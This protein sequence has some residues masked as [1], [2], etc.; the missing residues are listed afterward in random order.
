MQT[1]LMGILFERGFEVVAALCV[2]LASL[3]YIHMLQLESYQGKMY[4][5]WLFKRFWAEMLQFLLV[6]LIALLLRASYVFFVNT[7]ELIASICYIGADVV[8]VGMLL[9]MF[10]TARRG[11]PKKPLVF[12]GRIMR[13]C[14]T[15]CVL[16]FLFTAHFFVAVRYT[17]TLTWAQYLLPNVIRYLPGSIV[18]LFVMIAY[19]MIYP[20]EAAVKRWYFN[21]AKKK[22]ASRKDIV[23]I[24]ITGSFGK[25]STKYALGTILS[26]KYNVLFTQGS[27]NTP[28]GVTRVIRE[29]LK[30]EHQVFIAEMGARYKY[31][32]KELCDLVRPGYGIITSIGK[33][34]LETFGSMEG[35]INAKY[36]LIEALPDEGCC[37]FNAD[38]EYCR[39]MYEKT[40]L[41][42]KHMFGNEC[43]LYM[44]VS[45]ITADKN[46]SSF[47]LTA[48]DG[49]VIPCES[50]LLGKHNIDNIAAAAACAYRMGLAPEQ[51]AE[52]IKKIN[53]VE[54]RLQL[55][56]GAVTVIDDAFN[57]NPVGSAEALE[58]LKLF[59]GRRIVVT[60]GMVELGA[61][62]AEL[63]REFGRHMADC[64]DIAI[65]VG[66]AHIQPIR[67][68]LL[69]AGFDE[70][71]II[72]TATLSE[73]SE[74][75]P[76]FTE[77]G[78]VV[79]FEN[80]LPDNYNE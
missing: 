32:I 16:A 19:I 75:L 28:M 76:L 40:T 26:E 31:D 29:Q 3:Y 60:P 66:K 78:S 72:Q 71:C 80:D 62:E 51:I 36:E 4:L 18:P 57:A 61:E 63:N 2:M 73:A 1:E 68:G 58:I 43:G 37:F 21:D 12:T 77:H 59:D 49:V 13:L 8:Y 52:G 74:K 48:Q 27:F 10:F 33:Q 46:G 11:K 25:T 24:G 44:S 41:A 70:K 45:N 38:N 64:A 65:L 53:P 23:K 9:M 22:L 55:I 69:E 6:G 67:A 42:D 56:E 17:E 34:H 15:L 20:I 35:I 39:Q 54:H 30:D 14:V 5:R 47:T 7:N 79:L 50:R